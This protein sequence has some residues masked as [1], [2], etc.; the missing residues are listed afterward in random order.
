MQSSPRGA[1]TDLFCPRFPPLCWAFFDLEFETKKV[2]SVLGIEVQDFE[3]VGSSGC[4][5]L[6]A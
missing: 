5:F 6:V 4:V 2:Q 3:R 1:E